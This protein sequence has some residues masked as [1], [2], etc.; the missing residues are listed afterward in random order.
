[1][2][3]SKA[4]KL[5]IDAQID[6]GIPQTLPFTGIQHA[7]AALLFASEVRWRNF[8]LEIAR[9]H[10][11]EAS[12]VASDVSREA[13][14]WA[15]MWSHQK[16]KNC[17]ENIG[18][19][20]AEADIANAFQL[21]HVAAEYSELCDL[22][23]GTFQSQV[24]VKQI[25][26]HVLAW[27][28]TPEQLAFEAAQWLWRG[29][30]AAGADDLEDPCLRLIEWVNNQGEKLP[31][32]SS[33]VFKI[34]IDI[35]KE[36]QQLLVP[37]AE[38]RWQLPNDIDLKLFTKNQFKIFWLALMTAAVPHRRIYAETGIVNCAVPIGSLEQ[39]TS[40]IVSLSDLDVKIVSTLIKFLSYSI[41]TTKKV[42]H[43]RTANIIS[44]PFFALDENMLALSAFMTLGSSAER[45][46]FDLLSNKMSDEYEHIKDLKEEQWAGHLANRFSKLGFHAVPQRK[47]PDRG[48]DVD[49]FVFDSSKKL[50]L[51]VQLKW[52][53]VDRIKST[54]LEQGTSAIDQAKAS[55]AWIKNS[56]DQAS[57]V[58]NVP[59]ENLRQAR[60]LPI[61]IIKEGLL[62]GY[63]W[64][65]EV[66][67]ISDTVF[68]HAF[69]KFDGDIEKI[70]NYAHDHKFLPQLGQHYKA[71]RIASVPASGNP[72]N[73][74]NFQK[75]LLEK[76]ADWNP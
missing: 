72:F 6:A 44:Q 56:P 32:D 41:E 14:H 47:F 57:K 20:I 48:G 39:W 54:H 59:V 34:P 49:L 70:W 55:V 75:P 35:L 53:L 2:T 21:L 4:D 15:V 67:L 36:I 16:L 60:L 40:L 7:V 71:D 9:L 26:D 42:V 28:P 24:E 31:I 65:E 52:F 46:L 50:G 3:I 1:M 37:V 63:L 33:M 25:S 22:M 8:D 66:P 18:F 62:G 38:S 19:S 73:G 27:C 17:D 5:R 74:V 30:A 58:L 51:V 23:V 12:E 43:K 68:E 13:L 29:V 64:N 69:E 61:G 45:N 11:I 76:L 10:G